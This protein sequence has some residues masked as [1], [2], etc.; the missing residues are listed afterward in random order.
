MISVA[1]IEDNRLTRE[2]MAA[3]LGQTRDFRV[4]ASSSA[5][6]SFSDAR[7]Q[8]ILLDVELWDD[9]GLQVAETIRTEHADARVIVM[10]LRPGQDMIRFVSAGVAGFTLKDAT[11]DELVDTIRAVASGAYVLPCG[12]TSSLFAQVVKKVAVRGRIALHDVVRMTTRETEVVVLIGDGLSNKEIAARLDIAADT[13]KTH[14]RN[15]MEKLALHTRLQIAAYA[16]R[17]TAA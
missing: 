17:T 13:V 7:P 14:V 4:L 6:C 8:I 12:M 16:H 3:L 15:V 10:D 11:V 9:Q 1:L 5:S 2:G